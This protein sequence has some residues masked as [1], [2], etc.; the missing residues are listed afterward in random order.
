MKNKLA[1]LVI[2]LLTTSLSVSAQS[3]RAAETNVIYG[4]NRSLRLDV[5]L[6]EDAPAPYPVVAMFHGSPGDK[7]DLRNYQIPQLVV[8]AGYAA[9]TITYTT[10][11]PEAYRDAFCALA[12][13]TANAETYS[14][15]PERIAL[16]GLSYG[17]MVVTYAAAHDNPAVFQ[18]NCPNPIPDRF[19]IAGVIADAGAM[20]TRADVIATIRADFPEYADFADALAT[21]PTITWG[22]QDIAPELQPYLD[23]A[24]LYW[25]DGSEPPHLLIHGIG[26]SIVPYQTSVDYATELLAVNVNVVTVFDRLSGH[27]PAPRVFDAEMFTFLERVFD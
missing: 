20:T 21:Q 16:F 1:L 11:V 9:V 17:G 27:V 25:L 24:A 7:G 5:Y 8:N 26:D 22:G 23:Y 19:G 14:F 10:R 3:I 13:I 6:P 15:D 2:V 12:W 18:S 4:E